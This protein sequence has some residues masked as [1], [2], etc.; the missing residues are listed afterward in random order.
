MKRV[1]VIILTIAMGVS[2]SSCGQSKVTSQNDSETGFLKVISPKEFKEKMNEG[3]IVD[4]R[5]D[6]EYSSGHIK[7]A[8]NINY[9]DANHLEKFTSFDKKQPV[10]VYC[11]SGRR[12][13]AMAQEL[14]KIGFEKIYDLNGGI[15]A[16]QKAQFEI[17]K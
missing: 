8:V 12:S 5:T 15:L 6:R 4:V 10:F 11:R 7:N 13:N 16:W 2:M 14:K 17:V 9:F 1:A 3:T